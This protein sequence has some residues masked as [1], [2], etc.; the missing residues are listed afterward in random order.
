VTDTEQCKRQK[1]IEAGGA[2]ARAYTEIGDQIAGE[3]ARGD[4]NCEE[5]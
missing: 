5:T 3:C 1:Q 2:V 4:D